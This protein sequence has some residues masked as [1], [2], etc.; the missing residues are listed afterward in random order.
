M[1][2]SVITNAEIMMIRLWLQNKL[3][4]K[5]HVFFINVDNC[6]YHQIKDMIESND[7]NIEN[8]YNYYL[9]IQFIDDS[10]I[11]HWI[12]TVYIVNGRG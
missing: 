3:E 12:L 10:S 9:Y 11:S 6:N 4:K 8:K 1:N 5:N 7:E 2:Y